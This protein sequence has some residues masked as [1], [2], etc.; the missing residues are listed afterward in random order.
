M[1]A[2]LSLSGSATVAVVEGAGSRRAVVEMAYPSRFENPGLRPSFPHTFIS[3]SVVLL[4]MWRRVSLF[5]IAASII[6]YLLS[7]IKYL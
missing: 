1:C 2:T 4:G 6:E 3:P 5:S 7:M